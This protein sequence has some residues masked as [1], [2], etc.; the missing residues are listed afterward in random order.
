MDYVKL[1]AEIDDDPLARGYSGM[2]DQQVADSLNTADRV[3]VREEIVGNELFSYTDETEYL[4]LSDALKSQWLSLCSIDIIRKN[5]VPIIKSIF[6]SGSATWGNIVKTETLSRAE[7]LGLGL[8]SV[9]DVTF[10]RT[11]GY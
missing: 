6:N 5:A 3:V 8:V 1:K 2:T 7:E 9:A 4:A 11:G 10:V